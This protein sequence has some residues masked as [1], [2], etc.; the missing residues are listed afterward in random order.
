MKKNLTKFESYF[1]IACVRTYL[2]KFCK[3]APKFFQNQCLLATADIVMP[4]ISLLS[5]FNGKSYRQFTTVNYGCIEISYWRQ[6]TFSITINKT[7]H[8]A[9]WQSV[10]MLS[11]VMLNVKNDAFILSVD[12]LCVVMLSVVILSVVVTTADMSPCNVKSP[13]VS[14]RKLQQ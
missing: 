6:T 13:M 3:Q 5:L 8:S 14:R 4:S 11:I 10:V 1:L 7:R 2:K 9:L 12:I